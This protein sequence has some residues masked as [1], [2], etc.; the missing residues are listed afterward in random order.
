M[1]I[2]M[3]SPTLPWPLNTG[4]KI[5]IHHLLR[6]LSST[7]EVSLVTLVNQPEM[8]QID[9]IRPYCSALE[10][11]QVQKSRRAAILQASLSLQP[12]RAVKLQS[13]QFHTIVNRVAE[14]ATFDLIWVNILEMLGYVGPQLAAGATVVLD[15]QNADELVWERYAHH[16][17]WFTRA[18]AYQEL[19]KLRRFQS[20]HL[21][22][23]DVLLCVS[24]R[25]AGLMKGRVPDTCQVWTAPN[26]V[27]LD[28]FQMF[29][30]EPADKGNVVLLTGS[31]DVTMNIDAA[32][33]FAQ[34]IMP[35]VRDRVP[36]AEFWVVGRNPDRRVRALSRIPGVTV[37]GTVDDVRPFYAKAKVFVAPYRFGGGT[38]LKV[39]EAMATGVPVVSTPVGCQGIDVAPGEH[40]W[41]E[42]TGPRF[43]ERV[44]ELLEHEGRRKATL[45]PARQLVEEKYDWST[46][47]SPIVQRLESLTDSR[48]GDGAHEGRAGLQSGQ[49]PR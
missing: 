45:Q 49:T 48:L 4:E 31:M 33:T 10:V 21:S 38:K 22:S 5:R 27:D 29:S 28:F 17:G 39:L 23:V 7:N 36:A 1:R 9:A 32:V 30:G 43:A 12:Y 15:Q 18:F 19:R 24:E 46:V 2:L 11:V 20:K 40:C 47:L 13:A 8:G 42:E 44:I 26:G 25:D 35:V 41:V 3:L 16:G 6:E 37:T 14:R 34:D